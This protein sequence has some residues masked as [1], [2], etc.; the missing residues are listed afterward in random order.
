[1]TLRKQGSASRNVRL[2]AIGIARALKPKYASL[3]R[4]S[5]STLYDNMV[6]LVD[7]APAAGCR[8]V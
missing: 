4:V 1:M 7:P 8:S 3:I 6:S 2:T 5:S